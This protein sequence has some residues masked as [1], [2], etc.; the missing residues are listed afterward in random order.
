MVTVE[1]Y[2]VGQTIDQYKVLKPLS[3]TQ[4]S[5]VY[6]VQGPGVH[7]QQVLKLHAGSLATQ[8][9][10]YF[11]RQ[12]NL[13]L[14]FSHCP[15]II[16]VLH[17]GYVPA[18][19]VPLLTTKL[20]KNTH[21][22]AH[23]AHVENN[24][25][26]GR[27]FMVMPFYP[28]SL[29]DLLAVHNQKLS[30]VSSR[31]IIEQIL[32]G[33]ASI[34]KMGVVHLDI[35]PQNVFLDEHNNAVL[36]DFDNACVIESS[37]L[38]KQ[39]SGASNGPTARRITPD[40]ASPEQVI[41]ATAYKPRDWQISA[42]SDMYSLGVLWFRVLTGGVPDSLGRV[43]RADDNSNYLRLLEDFAPPWAI[44]LV[45]QL[46]HEESAKR[47]SASECKAIML[48]NLMTSQIDHT[49]L[50]GNE[51][52]PQASIILQ[53]SVKPQKKRAASL[54]RYWLSGAII[55]AIF[56]YWTY[57]VYFHPTSFIHSKNTTG[58]A[59]NDP[60]LHINPQSA[61]ASN[62]DP[63]SVKAGDT[64]TPVDA[65]LLRPNFNE[66]GRTVAPPA[67]DESY[68]MVLDNDVR[69]D[70]LILSDLPGRKVMRTEVSNALFQLCIED[71]ACRHV[72]QFSTSPKHE[73][74]PQDNYPKV[75]VDWYEVTEQF[76]PWL[77]HKVHKRFAL[78][79]VREWKIM[80]APDQQTIAIKGVMHCKDCKHDFVRK[81]SGASMPVDIT[82]IAT[83]Q[84][85]NN[86][87][88]HV[89]GNVQEWLNDCWQQQ[90]RDKVLIERCDQAMVAG[91]SWMNTQSQ[92]IA[93][94]V[95]RLLKNAKTPTTGF[96]LVEITDE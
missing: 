71:G 80:S 6:V 89:Y 20:P 85:R 48:A 96:R 79:S 58:V 87:L 23:G 84:P 67:L 77:S 64:S 70:W 90:S 81:Y 60:H 75:N 54:M 22:N 8:S 27:P 14:A 55:I 21:Q 5:H 73:I 53:T 43:K 10:E 68:T 66:A 51:P 57:E 11:M 33:L 25:E 49:L 3:A 91:G 72:K 69:I 28:Q 44:D 36:A 93:E 41:G 13:L 31:R 37:P 94:P 9:S 76:I 19:E 24:V 74:I 83:A 62:N 61:L 12:A 40:Y 26:S 56:A 35:K 7:K 42:P 38:A 86:S 59:D 52:L 65:E 39:F 1:V 82:P 50:V 17:I 34:H 46:T 4:N 29:S 16:N 18:F 15:H 63:L 78:P 2:S 95:S 30:F 47:P 88:Y 92:I 32:D 45:A